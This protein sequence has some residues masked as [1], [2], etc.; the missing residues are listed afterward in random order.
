VIPALSRF[1]AGWILLA[2]LSAWPALVTAGSID[3]LLAQGRLEVES[4][5]DPSAGIVPGQKVSLQLKVST[6][7][8]FSGGTRITLPEVPGLVILQTEQFASNASETRQGESWVTQSWSL[9]VYPQRAG[10]FNVGPIKL[11]V[12]VN[13]GE[14]GN[15]EGELSA[16]ALR[17]SV[18]IPQALEQAEQWVA[19]PSFKVSQSFDRPLESLQVGDAF[20]REIVFEASDVMAMML[21]SVA[22]QKTPGLAAYSTPPVLNNSNNRGQARASRIQQISYVVE[23]E[24][25]YQLPA[26]EFLWWDTTRARLQL[27]SL[28]ATEIS[29]GT[30]DATPGESIVEAFE[31][32]PRQLLILA[33]GLL[34]LIATSA[35]AWKYLPR[36]PLKRVR[37]TLSQLYQQLANLRKPALPSQLNPGSS[38]GE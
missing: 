15:I 8:W 19:S 35:L 29:V 10:D 27:L 21:P 24:G 31:I 28:P 30:G 20:Q 6:E 34:L 37:A 18:A 3:T 13:A 1:G 12:K 38:A 9:V 14:D 32:S 7:H 26:L 25:R 33:T 16:P 2:L 5:L 22:V 11:R 36:L 23:D 17:F 4:S